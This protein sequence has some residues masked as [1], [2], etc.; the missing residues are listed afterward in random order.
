[1]KFVLCARRSRNEDMK[2]V[3]LQTRPNLLYR[4]VPSTFKTREIFMKNVA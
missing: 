1:M 2:K 4:P 3:D